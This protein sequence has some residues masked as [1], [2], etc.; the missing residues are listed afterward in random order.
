MQSK[1]VSQLITGHQKHSKHIEI[2]M[3][4]KPPHI[5]LLLRNESSGKKV[6]DLYVF[7]LEGHGSCSR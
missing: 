4:E 5:S 2:Q 7:S 1:S 6:F 3:K